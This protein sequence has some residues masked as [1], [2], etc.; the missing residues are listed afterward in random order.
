MH[1]SNLWHI[2]LWGPPPSHTHCPL[3]Q[4]AIYTFVR[5][6]YWVPRVKWNGPGQVRKPVSLCSPGEHNRTTAP[7][8]DKAKGGTWALSVKHQLKRKITQREITEWT[9]QLWLNSQGKSMSKD[10]LHQVPKVVLWAPSTAWQSPELGASE[11]SGFQPEYDL[12]LKRL[13]LQVL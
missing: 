7:L 1:S 13:N 8:K 4:W 3:P 10:T 2:K 12:S 5:L 6:A 9:G 11:S